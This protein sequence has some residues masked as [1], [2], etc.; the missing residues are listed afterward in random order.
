MSA[1]T[2]NPQ[3]PLRFVAYVS[4]YAGE[5]IEAD[6]QAISE[7]A[8]RNNEANGLTGV[9]LYDRGLFV[10]IIE[11]EWAEVGALLERIRRDARSDEL[12]V[13]IDQPLSER[14]FANW[15]FE[16]HAVLE[17]GSP[18]HRA[19]LE[20]LR[21]AYLKT[22]RPSPSEFADIVSSFFG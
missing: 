5:Q 16:A 11:G 4:R 13:L 22:F 15:S 21:D 18:E 17:Q 3:Q 7:A 8:A 12:D 19:N 14:T 1:S 10:Q 20:R 2:P 6:L 9:L